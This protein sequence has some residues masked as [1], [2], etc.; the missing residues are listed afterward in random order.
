MNRADKTMLL[1]ALG[2]LGLWYFARPRAAGSESFAGK[3]VFIT[4][5]SRG[6]GLVLARKFTLEGARV[7]ICARDARELERAAENVASCGTEPITVVADVADASQIREAIAETEAHLG[8]IQILINNAGI[9][10]VGPVGAMTRADFEEALQVS[11]WGAYN[12][13]EAVLPGMKMRKEGRIVNVSSIGG[14][15]GVPHLAP[16]CV[17]KFALA[18][19]SQAL[20][21]ELASVGIAVTTVYPGLMRTGSPRNASFKGN[22]AAEFGWFK[23][24]DSLP[25]LTVSAEDAAAEIIE[26]VRRADAE[27]VIS[28]PAK[29]GIMLNALCPE[30]MA[31]L[32]TL[33]NGLLPGD[34][35]VATER[36]LGKECDLP[37][38][39][40]P[41][42]ILTDHA[43][44]Q[45]NEVDPME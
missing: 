27:V 34:G 28:L 9:I 29:V 43:A 45:N 2:G 40:A 14:K 15:I 37:G 38:V 4:G 31:N 7:A 22:H 24:S 42:T 10:S 19:Y 25:L 12:A 36:K 3:T 1:C 8:P 18:G 30:I 23:V 6:L 26:A 44:A 32:I 11:F 33:A 17:G 20:R 35:G 39:L 13:I 16:Y 5:G 21:A 41:L